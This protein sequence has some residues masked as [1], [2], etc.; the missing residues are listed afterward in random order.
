MMNIEN[1]GTSLHLFSGKHC[2]MSASGL[3]EGGGALWT[4]LPPTMQYWCGQ[5]PDAMVCQVQSER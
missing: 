3:G 2:L 1:V 4:H 5:I